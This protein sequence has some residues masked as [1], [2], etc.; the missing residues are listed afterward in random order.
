MVFKHN[1]LRLQ[2][3]LKF[4][5]YIKYIFNINFKVLIAHVIKAVLPSYLFL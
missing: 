4:I 3:Y 1:I 2:K 5:Y